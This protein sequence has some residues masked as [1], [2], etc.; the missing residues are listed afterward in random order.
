MVLKILLWVKKMK[1]NKQKEIII[2]STKDPIT[3]AVIYNN[4]LNINREMGIAMIKTSM[5]PIFAE[6]HDFSCAICDWDNRI[7]AQADGVP[8]HTA[9]VAEAVKAVVEEFKN[10][11]HSGDIFIM[12]DPYLGGTH[13]ADITVIKP[14]FFNKKLQFFS[15][16]RAHHSDV[17]GLE[18][19]SYCPTA[20]EIFHEGLRIPPLRIFQNEK[21]INDIIN[22]IK[23]NTRMPDVLWVDMK[24]Q[25]ASCKV[26]EKRL[27]ELFKK[28]GEQTVRN[29]VEDIHVYAENRMRDEIAKLKDGVYSA[30][31]FLDSDGFSN[32]PVKIRVTITIKENEAF[33]DFSGTDCQVA[34]YIN[35]PLANTKTSVYVAFLLTVTTP[36]IPHNEGVYRPIKVFAP[37]GT[38]VNP[39]FPAPVAACTLD[40]ACAVLEVCFKA[41]SQVV[42]DRSPAGWNRYN[43]GIISGIDPRNNEFYVMFG[44]NSF[45]GAGGM[46][47]M[48]GLHYVGDGIDLGGLISPNIETNEVNYPN[49]TEFHEF[50]TDSCGAGKFRGGCGAKYKIKCYDENPTIIMMGDGKNNPPYGLLGGKPGS[51]NKAFINE[52]SSME[53]EIKV[54]GKITINKGDTFST[55]S[56]GG[57]G[58]GNPYERDVKRVRED[59]LNEII[60]PESALHDY[61]VVLEGKD[62]K[63][64]LEK[65]ERYRRKYY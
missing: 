21:P 31:T 61:G 37:E 32:K 4:L 65:T 15:I 47:G 43:G 64:N 39:N 59:V 50:A 2:E 13:L 57:G 38:V 9:S 8:S 44:F 20:T 36:D 18:A 58:W 29:I 28:Y 23:I 33:V 60:S 22:T 48:D 5:S 30:E 16:N 25:I 51:S 19:G 56:S 26:G 41:L 24:A 27:V 53:I 42:P 11:I 63:I 6:V 55:Y 17:G 7:I 54:N 62:F 40:T 34:S 10:D 49:I 1:D 45:G 35:S 14:I 3:F 52:G 12:N 46:K